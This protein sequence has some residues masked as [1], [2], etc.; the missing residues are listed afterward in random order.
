MAQD[1]GSRL[2]TVTTKKGLGLTNWVPGRKENC[3]GPFRLYPDC[4]QEKRQLGIS[5]VGLKVPFLS[6]THQSLWGKRIC[7]VT[8]RR[9]RAM[10]VKWKRRISC[11]VSSQIQIQTRLKKIVGWGWGLARHQLFLQRYLR[12]W[13]FWGSEG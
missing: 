8:F 6:P 13:L 1:F 2:S 3:S 7:H 9:A 4:S 11:P 12:H 10:R 5:A